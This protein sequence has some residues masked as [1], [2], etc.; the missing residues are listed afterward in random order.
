MSISS[1]ILL[2]V[3]FL[4]ILILRL[5]STKS[6]NGKTYRE[7]SSISGN[8][9]TRFIAQT[10]MPTFN[11]SPDVK[12]GCLNLQGGDSGSSVPKTPAEILTAPSRYR[13]GGGGAVQVFS[14]KELEVATEKFSEANVIGQGVFGVV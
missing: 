12:G 3:I 4:I 10:S 13:R 5:K 8:T 9:S 11:S 1:V 6:Y 2:L 14:Y 7:N